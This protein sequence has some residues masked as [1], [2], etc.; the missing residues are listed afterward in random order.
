MPV[1]EGSCELAWPD[2]KQEDVTILTCSGRY[3]LFSFGAMMVLTNAK[4]RSGP[5]HERF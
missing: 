5:A 3:R 1:P 4:A 2:V